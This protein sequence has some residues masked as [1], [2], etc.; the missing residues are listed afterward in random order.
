[1]ASSPVQFPNPFYHLPLQMNRHPASRN[2]AAL[3]DLPQ[4]GRY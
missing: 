3:F 2:L 1:M 4:K